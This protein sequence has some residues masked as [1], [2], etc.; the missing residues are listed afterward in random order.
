MGQ[1][2]QQ[3]SAMSEQEFLVDVHHK[4]CVSEPFLHEM[5]KNVHM[6]NEL[7]SAIVTLSRRELKSWV[8]KVPSPSNDGW[9]NDQEVLIRLSLSW[10]LKKNVFIWD[11]RRV[12]H[13]V[14]KLFP[15]NIPS[16]NDFVLCP[17]KKSSSVG[18]V[19]PLFLED[20]YIVT[21]RIEI[22]KTIVSMSPYFHYEVVNI[23]RTNL[24]KW[25]RHNSSVPQTVRVQVRVNLS[26][27]IQIDTLQWNVDEVYHE[28]A[29]LFPHTRF[30]M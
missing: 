7:Y 17:V 13:E 12:F 29:K 2:L 28:I 23:S 1:V 6:S 14:S 3:A 30:L 25:Y 18:F 22:G 5:G 19:E 9:L 20:T 15:G 11:K 27:I 10:I 16:Y 26:W 21:D 4:T 24:K 8:I